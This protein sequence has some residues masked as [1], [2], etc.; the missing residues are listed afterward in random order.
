MGEVCLHTPEPTQD[1]HSENGNASSGGDTSECLLRARFSVRE[2]V[3][4]DHDCDQ[5]RH[6]GDGSGEEHFK[7]RETA[8]EGRAADLR[9]SRDS[10][11]QENY[12]RKCSVAET[13]D[14]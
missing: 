11:S 10:E 12:N 14:W 3:A 8:I 7:C 5:A 6:P 13:F 2:T 9:K 1:I 4:A